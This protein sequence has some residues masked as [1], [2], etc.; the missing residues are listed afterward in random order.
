VTTKSAARFATSATTM[1]IE[2]GNAVITA[3]QIA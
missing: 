3:A 2:H 1:L